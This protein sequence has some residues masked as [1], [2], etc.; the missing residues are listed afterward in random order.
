M[1]KIESKHFTKNTNRFKTATKKW[2]KDNSCAKNKYYEHFSPE[3]WTKTML[4]PKKK[5]KHKVTCKYC[6]LN[7]PAIINLF[8]SKSK[9]KKP[10]LIESAKLN[11]N[12]SALKDY[13]NIVYNISKQYQNK[14][15][16]NFADILVETQKR[17][18]KKATQVQ[19]KGKKEIKLELLQ[20]T[21][22]CNGMK[23]LLSATVFRTL[24][25]A[26]IK[27]T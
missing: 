24:N 10:N 16:L 27:T 6:L 12:K 9:N 11:L 8:P 20:V 2:T 13:T 15:G 18:Q 14:L 21:W 3:N 25:Y 19:K 23:M 1:K 5:E 26:S 7:F 22:K 17:L 4:K